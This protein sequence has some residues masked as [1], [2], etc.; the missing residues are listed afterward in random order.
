MT[1]IITV[2]TL[3]F[4]TSASSASAFAQEGTDEACRKHVEAARQMFRSGN[5]PPVSEGKMPPTVPG[6]IQAMREADAPEKIPEY[7]VGVFARGYCMATIDM[8]MRDSQWNS[9]P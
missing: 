7:M 1:H 2:V 4:S 9:K 8:M 3:A 6:H 5:Y